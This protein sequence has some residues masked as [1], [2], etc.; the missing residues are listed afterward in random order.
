MDITEITDVR[1]GLARRLGR[2]LTERSGPPSLR[3]QLVL[4]LSAFLL[5][6]VATGLLFVGIWRHTAAEGDAARTQQLQ[7]ARRLHA[8][9]TKLAALTTDLQA[10]QARVA[11]AS[12]DLRAT[13]T[14]LAS[15]RRREARLT[16][17][18]AAHVDGVVDN[19]AAV[20]HR[21]TKLR[22]ALSSIA[23]YLH[24]ASANGVDPAFVETQVRYVIASTSAA[25]SSAAAVS[26][27]AAR[28]QAAVAQLRRK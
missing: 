25:E 8:V 20:A 5:G 3:A 1:S 10:A 28:A 17:A 6:G 2:A 11:H 16:P 13:R 4:L 19:A 7:A 22:T 24:D 18:L 21:T 9:N 26:A 27:D 15:L 23:A 12:R 14:E